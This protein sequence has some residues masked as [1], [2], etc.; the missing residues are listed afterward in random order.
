MAQ[1]GGEARKRWRGKM[2]QPGVLAPLMPLRL[3]DLDTDTLEK[4]ATREVSKRPTPLRLGF[5]LLRAFLN[6][7]AEQEGMADLV[8]PG[9]ASTKKLKT[10]LGKPQPKSDVL[11]R[12]QLPAWFQQV[13]SIENPVVSVYLQ[14]LLLTGARRNEMLGLRW[15]EVDTRW[16]SLTIR[17]KVGDTRQI[18]L[19]PY[20]EARLSELPRRNEWVFSSSRGEEGRLVDPNPRHRQVC[21]CA[22]IEGLTLHGLRRSF[23]SL[24]EWLELPVGVVAQIMGHKPS[25]TAEKHY[26]IR[27]LDLLRIHHERFEC[28]LLQHAKLVDQDD[29]GQA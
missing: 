21:K 27:P 1:S 4:L 3:A 20:L 16:K 17:D 7:S 24:S 23:K 22:G 12:E 5:R 10:I 8:N 29:Q 18:P 13:R 26:T 6:W 14:A 28:W 25:A 19:T 11:L 15:A 2:L 9:I